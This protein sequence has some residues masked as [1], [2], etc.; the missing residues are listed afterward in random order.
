MDVQQL[1]YV[2]EVARTGSITQA[3]KNLYMG[4]PNLSKSIR[5]LEDEIGIVLFCRTAQGTRPT[6]SGEAFLGYARSIVAQ[7]DS[8]AGMYRP[9]EVPQTRLHVSVPRASYVAASFGAYL[10]SLAGPLD[11]SY[12]ETNALAIITEVAHGDADMGVLR[13]QAAHAAHF[14]QLLHEN[15]LA[16]APL[17]EYAMVVLMHE[18]HPLAGLSEIPYHLLAQYPQI[19]HG[20][21]T[22]VLP[23]EQDP[24]PAG[25]EQLAARSRIA[26]F[27]RGS[28]FDILQSVRGSYL[29]VSPM[30]FAVLA[31]RELVQK[32]CGSATRYCDVIVHR[33]GQPLTPVQQGF[34]DVL[35]HDVQQLVQG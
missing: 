24:S 8:L 35:A 5:E 30:P 25:P 21:F 2:L 14:A 11:V 10:G 19:V 23:P 31:E 20:D 29:W 16:A 27:D 9:G 34:A 18:R 32:R 1:R 26:V 17:W 7:M 22:P 28:Q 33:A 12:H 3:A 4:Q 13:Y 6:K 15:R